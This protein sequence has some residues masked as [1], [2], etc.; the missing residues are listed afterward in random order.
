MAQEIERKFLVRGEFKSQAFKQSRMIQGYICSANGRTVRVRI[1]DDQGFLTIKGPTN[2]SGTTRFE[3]EKEIPVSD[4]RELIKLCE[5][6]VISKTRFYVRSGS[7]VFEVDE[8]YDAN[9]GLIMAEVEL[10][11]ENEEFV[12]PEFIGEEVTG[13]VRYYNSQLMRRPYSTW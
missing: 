10:L 12:K 7:H 11:D 4:A 1:A 6:G 8:F 3:W 9:Q 5:G 13:D 2:E